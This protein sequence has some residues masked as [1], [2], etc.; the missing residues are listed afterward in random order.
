MNDGFGLSAYGLNKIIYCKILEARW[1]EILK[2][3]DL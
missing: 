2:N 3:K 1:D